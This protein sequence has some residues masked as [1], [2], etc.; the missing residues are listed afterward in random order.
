MKGLQI[1]KH[2]PEAE[3]SLAKC[4]VF[5]NLDWREGEQRLLRA[6]ELDPSLSAGHFNYAILLLQTARFESALLELLRA[7]E[8]DPL[9]LTIG[10]GVA[11]AH[12]YVGRYER[13]AEECRKVFEL[14]PNYFEAQG[15]MGLVAIAEG[16]Y[17]DAVTCFE[18]AQ[19]G[20][21]L[22]HGFLGYALALSGSAEAAREILERLKQ[23]AA[24]RY[25]SAVAP[26]IIHVGLSEPEEALNWLEKAVSAKEAFVAYAAVFPPFQPLRE[27]PRFQTLLKA[28]F[29][30]S[31]LLESSAFRYAVGQ[32]FKAAAQTMDLTHDEHG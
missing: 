16:R 20:S 8:L 14:Q 32:G 10:T 21:P 23:L 1:D 11:W 27:T 13:A 12:Y 22:G 9:S 19:S 25:I 7:R 26:A 28:C 2:L 29:K 5:S 15:C 4:A 30:G 17:A 31:S 18:R 3:I 6:I 24:E